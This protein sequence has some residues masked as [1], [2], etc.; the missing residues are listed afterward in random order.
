MVLL[1]E[2]NQEENIEPSK[3]DI[4]TYFQ[5]FLELD[6]VE[7]CDLMWIARL[8]LKAPLPPNWKAALTSK[9]N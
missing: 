1:T 5:T 6:L 3:E 4:I 9:D 8:G 7:D 2:N